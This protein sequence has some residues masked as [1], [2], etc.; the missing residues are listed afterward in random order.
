VSEEKKPRISAVVPVYNSAECLPD[1]VERLSRVLAQCS[2]AF[3]IIFV[4]DGSRDASWQ[5]TRSLAEQF[6]FLRGLNLSRNYGQHNALLAGIRAARYELVVTLDDDLQNPPEEI[7]K[8]IEEL[9]RSGA[10]VVYGVPREEEHGLWRDLASQFTKFTLQ[11]VMGVRI[12]QKVSAFRIFHTS[13]RQAFDD[14]NSPEICIDVLLS[15]GT[16]LF[17]SVVVEHRPRTL[18]KSNYTL[19]K[20][21]RHAVNM[22]TGYS[23][24]PLR[25]ATFL[26]FAFV[27]LGICMFLYVIAIRL[28]VKGSVPGFPFLAATISMFSGVQLFSVGVIGEY[29]GRIHQRSLDRPVYVVHNAINAPV[30]SPDKSG[31]E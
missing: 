4:N 8:L 16:S 18:G 2:R 21:V 28:L 14:F 12:A 3:E 5:V 1:L 29:V 26:G 6:P 30:E 20:L 25:I 11:K 27:L 22:T 23:L 24:L 7:P 9:D 15:W 13:V 31:K 17:S 19:W 10:D